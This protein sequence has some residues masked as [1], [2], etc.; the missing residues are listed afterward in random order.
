MYHDET[1]LGMQHT[2]QRHR[3]RFP[4]L[5]PETSGH[6]Q[7]IWWSVCGYC[8]QM[9][10]MSMSLFT[11]RQ[12]RLR[13]HCVVSADDQAEGGRRSERHIHLPG[14]SGRGV[15]HPSCVCPNRWIHRRDDR[16][17]GGERC[18]PPWLL[19]SCCCTGDDPRHPRHPRREV[20]LADSRN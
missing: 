9:L 8:M 15:G 2:W 6:G 4:A 5:V 14:D 17:Q 1:L 18:L 13:H 16:E 20:T 3:M 11:L 19:V 7:E 10:R 12:V